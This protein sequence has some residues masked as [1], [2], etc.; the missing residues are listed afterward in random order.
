MTLSSPDH[1][2]LIT[3]ALFNVSI[4]RTQ[5]PEDWRFEENIWID[6]EGN[7]VE[8]ELEFEVTQYTP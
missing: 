7:V 6:G 5:M 2:A 1:V 3:H 4:P 8:G